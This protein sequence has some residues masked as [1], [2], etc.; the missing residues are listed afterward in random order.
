MD[1]VPWQHF[2]FILLC[3]TPE[4]FR[5]WCTMYEIFTIDDKDK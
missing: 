5:G 2:D 3:T 4:S 1:E